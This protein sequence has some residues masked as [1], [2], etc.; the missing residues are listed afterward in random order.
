MVPFKDDK[1]LIDLSLSKLYGGVAKAVMKTAVM[2][3]NI[4]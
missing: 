4:P 1:R 2:L 3:M